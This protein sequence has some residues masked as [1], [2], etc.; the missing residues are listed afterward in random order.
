[1]FWNSPDTCNGNPIQEKKK[2]LI[3]LEF[4]R[5][6]QCKSNPGEEERIDCFGV[7]QTH[8][9]QI[10]S[11]RK[12]NSCSQTTNCFLFPE[13]YYILCGEALKTNKSVEPSRNMDPAFFF[14]TTLTLIAQKSISTTK[15]FKGKQ[16]L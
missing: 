8:A 12:R 3:V 16:T 13:N 9:M 1:L 7:L 6:I 15:Q 5:H 14:V 4:S 11:R 2:G 10:Q